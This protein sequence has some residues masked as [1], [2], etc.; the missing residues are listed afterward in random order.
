MNEQWLV[1]YQKFSVLL[2]SSGVAKY[3][4]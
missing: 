1:L 4:K 2:G 3:L